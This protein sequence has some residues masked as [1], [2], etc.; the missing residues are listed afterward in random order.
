ME[1]RGLTVA[2]LADMSR[3]DIVGLVA[4]LFGLTDMALRTGKLLSGALEV[5]LDA[6]F[7]GIRFVPEAGPDGRGSV[8]IEG[9][10]DTSRNGGSPSAGREGR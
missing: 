5:D 2:D 1:G 6:A 8:V 10:D 3:V 7:V 4:I 9:E